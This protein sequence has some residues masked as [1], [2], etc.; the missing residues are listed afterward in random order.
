[1]TPELMLLLQFVRRVRYKLRWKWR[2]FMRFWDR[3]KWCFI[4]GL[5][6]AAARY[7]IEY[8]REYLP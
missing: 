4:G 3:F 5:G 7:L 1:M 6:Y 2:K 8:V